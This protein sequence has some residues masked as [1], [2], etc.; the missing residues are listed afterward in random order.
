[1]PSI[2]MKNNKIITSPA[3]LELAT[4]GK[5]SQIILAGDFNCPDIDWNTL[6]VKN[7]AQDKE[8]QQALVDVAIDFNLTQVHEKPT[9]EDNL[10]ST[11]QRVDYSNV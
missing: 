5:D 9:R 3:T 10:L 1:M 11:R 7:N 2:P 4:T 6:T 8:I